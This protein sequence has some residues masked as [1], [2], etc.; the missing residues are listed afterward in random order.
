[1][2]IPTTI[3]VANKDVIVAII[4]PWPIRFQEM[5][6]YVNTTNT[7]NNKIRQANGYI[8]V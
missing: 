4:M 2:E 8:E 5:K 1:M 6:I 3:M 7:R